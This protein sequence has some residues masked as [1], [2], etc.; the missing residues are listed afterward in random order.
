MG[1]AIAGVKDMAWIICYVVFMWVIRVFVCAMCAK[2]V[3]SIKRIT[4]VKFAK[5]VRG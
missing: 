2:G 1:L 4:S 3:V 5:W